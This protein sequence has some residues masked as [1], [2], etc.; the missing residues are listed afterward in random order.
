MGNGT[1]SI[2]M[3]YQAVLQKASRLEELAKELSMIAEN[4]IESYASNRKVWQG[5]S[6]DAFRQKLTKEENN[7]KKKAKDLNKTADRLRKT[8]KRQY[9]IEKKL[10]SLVSK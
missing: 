5:D 7:L 3:D 2:Y 10:V 1:N 9:E 8:A 4:Q 6:G